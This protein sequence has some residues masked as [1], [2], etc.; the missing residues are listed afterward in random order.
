MTMYFKC[1]LHHFDKKCLILLNIKIV[2]A[3]QTSR[4]IKGKNYLCNS[5][6][7]VNTFKK[8]N[9]ESKK[10]QIQEQKWFSPLYRLQ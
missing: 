3:S 7:V 10:G 5:N 9:L 6:L 8:K 1:S 2:H 4:G